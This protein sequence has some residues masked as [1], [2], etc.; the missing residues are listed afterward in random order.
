MGTVDGERDEF[1]RALPPEPC[2]YLRRFAGPRDR[3]RG[4]NAHFDRLT[5]PELSDRAE[6]APRFDGATHQWREEK[7]KDR[8]ADRRASDRA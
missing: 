4:G 5:D 7:P 3:S 2:R 1:A 6:R 8:H